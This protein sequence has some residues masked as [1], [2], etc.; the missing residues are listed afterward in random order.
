[1][2][3]HT[4]REARGCA[5]RFSSS[6]KLASIQDSVHVMLEHDKRL[7]ARTGQAV[8]GYVPRTPHPLLSPAAAAAAA[9]PSSSSENPAS[10]QH[11]PAP[12]Q[13]QHKRQQRASAISAVE[14]EEEDESRTVDLSQNESD[15]EKAR[16]ERQRQSSSQQLERL[17]WHA[18]HHSTT[19]DPRDAQLS[20]RNLSLRIPTRAMV[21][22]PA[23]S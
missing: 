12:Q 13:Q 22:V 17:C 14:E 19:V 6:S 9:S 7:C 23:E 8:T 1:M 5:A 2:G 16:R 15:E 20:G 3:C 4:S 10:L 18:A 11:A 21:Q